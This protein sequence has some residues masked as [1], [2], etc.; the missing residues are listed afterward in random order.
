MADF[1][2]FDD[3]GWPIKARYQ[4]TNFR[5][6]KYWVTV[7]EDPNG[8]EVISGPI[9]QKVDGKKFFEW[10]DAGEAYVMDTT[11]VSP[12]YVRNPEYGKK[13]KYTI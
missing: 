11:S 12:T 6:E 13:S 9:R 4:N 3:R 8:Y 7:V 1:L 2:G 10:P 5:G